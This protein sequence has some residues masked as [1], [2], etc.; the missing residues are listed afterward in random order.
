[1]DLWLDVTHHLKQVA[2][3]PFPVLLVAGLDATHLAHSLFV[4]L[5][6]R[7]TMGSKSLM[8]KLKTDLGHLTRQTTSKHTVS[9]K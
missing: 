7:V 8:E 3:H 2:Q 6:S 4:H 5:Y 9:I 1:M